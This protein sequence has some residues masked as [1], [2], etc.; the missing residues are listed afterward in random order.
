MTTS[1]GT[2]ISEDPVEVSAGQLN[3][4]DQVTI[5]FQVR[6]ANPIPPGVAEIV[7]QGAV[8]GDGLEDVLSDDPDAG[9]DADPTVTAITAAPVLTVE[10]TD[11]LF[12]DADGDSLASP[13]DELLY[14]I[15]VDNSGNTAATS[16]S[17]SD[18]ISANTSLVAGTVQTSHGSVVS[19]DPVEVSLG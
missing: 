8:A 13:G 9:G 19:E 2:V 16:V 4:G 3:V 15:E 12:N 5:G 10:K 6:I 11:T 14:R 1:A 7:N 17:L 18:Q